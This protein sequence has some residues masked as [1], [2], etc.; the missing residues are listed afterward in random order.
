MSMPENP[1]YRINNRFDLNNP[2]LIVGWIDDASGIGERA[3]D[4]IHINTGGIPCAEIL[5]EGFFAMAGVSVENDIACF[6]ESTFYGDS[7]NN[8][9][10]LKSNIPHTDWYQFLHGIL[11]VADSYGV[12]EIYTMGTMVSAASH[13]MPRVLMA[14]LNNGD[15]AKDLEPYNIMTGSDFETPPGQKPTFSSYLGWVAR[16]REIDVINLWVTSPFYLVQAEDPRACKRLIYFFNDRFGLGIDF[17][18]INEEIAMQNSKIAGLYEISPEIQE[19][20][21]KLETGEGLDA[22]QTEK[23]VQVIGNHLKDN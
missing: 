22:E 5:P 13:T 8:L 21:R 19:M 20:V 12:K 14:V 7:K 2:K 18:G 17:T 3:L 10:I 9:L 4:Y 15:L 11:D 16:Q 23:L 1:V 6:P